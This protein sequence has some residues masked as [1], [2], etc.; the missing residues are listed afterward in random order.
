MSATLAQQIGPITQP[1]C[2]RTERCIAPVHAGLHQR[3]EIARIVPLLRTGVSVPKALP[4][5]TAGEMIESGARIRGPGQWPFAT[6]FRSE[7]IAYPARP[8][9]PIPA[10]STIPTTSPGDLKSPLLANATGAEC[11][12]ESLQGNEAT[13]AEHPAPSLDTPAFGAH[14]RDRSV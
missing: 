8:I 4:I 14:G 11:G 10:S 9:M 2:A 3:C 13:R 1:K 6:T 5:P 12:A 7:K